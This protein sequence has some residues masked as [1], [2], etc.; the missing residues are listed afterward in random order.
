V[1][2]QEIREVSAR[3][4]ARLVGRDPGAIRKELE[5]VRGAR[6][7]DGGQWRVPLWAWREYQANRD[8]R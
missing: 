4:L 2:E 1:I 6:R 3:E 8:A 7:T 5:H